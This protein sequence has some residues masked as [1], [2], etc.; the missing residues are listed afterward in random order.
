MTSLLSYLWPW[1]ERGLIARL[2]ARE[3]H[4]RYR[5]SW[6]GLAWLVLTPLA[7]LSIYTL[8]FRHVMRVR[9]HG[10]DEGNLAFGLRIYAGLAVF[11]F[12]AECVNRAPGLVLE[13]PNLVKKVVFPLQILP[14]VS[15]ASAALG[16]AVSGALLVGLAVLA[17][18]SLPLTA[19]A[20]PLVW[21]PLLPLVLGLSWLL[22][23]L[24]TYVRDVGQVLT[25]AVSAL[26]FLS[27]IFFPV[28]AL[29]AAVRPWL[30]LNPLAWVMTGT[31]DVLLA[32]RWPDW[33]AWA[34][35]MAAC[36]L[37]ALAGAAFFRK[38]RV[39]FADVV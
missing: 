24:G 3:V 9:W 13:Q 30:L 39:G 26:M 25:M 5:Q 37:L 20:L 16:L 38:V 14:W 23:G 18:G 33:G 27:P 6:L 31:R 19:L 36:L 2:A 34:L 32:G 10:V 11:S 35:L 4:A 8:V 1:R 17:N 28:E 7:M 21:L 15:A 22:A 12:F 29:P